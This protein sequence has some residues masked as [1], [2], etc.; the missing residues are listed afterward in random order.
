MTI[1]PNLFAFF[2]GVITDFLAFLFL[3]F[4]LVFFIR[5]KRF[6]KV[7]MIATLSG[8]TLYLAIVAGTNLFYTFDTIDRN[9]TQP[10]PPAITSPDGRY[11]AEATYELY[12]GV[13]G[14]V[15]VWVDVVNTET[16]VTKTIYYAGAV[17]QVE[18][19]WLDEETLSIQNESIGEYGRDFNVALNVETE[20]FHD[21]G[22]ACWS[23]L[24]K[25]EY[26]RCYSE[27]S[28]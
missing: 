28:K 22:K 24:M 23:L 5:R 21:Q 15:N 2:I 3:I 1:I 10:G 11:E 12:G 19:E 16:R 6:P 14:G 7:L 17:D 27:T 13:L 20:I 26:E 18:L 4:L 25:K 9:H 8:A